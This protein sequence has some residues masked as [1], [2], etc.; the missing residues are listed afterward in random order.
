MLHFGKGPTCLLG[1]GK[2][3][4]GASGPMI[5]TPDQ[6][7][8]VDSTVTPRGCKICTEAFFPYSDPAFLP[9]LWADERN[10]SGTHFRGDFDLFGGPDFIKGS[11]FSCL[12]GRHQVA[13]S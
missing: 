5:L 11:Q 2:V 1:P 4:V 9:F 7:H 3:S 10:N 12:P 8:M 6:W 13:T